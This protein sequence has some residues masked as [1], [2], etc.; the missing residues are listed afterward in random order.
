MS[1]VRLVG[2]DANGTFFDDTPQF[3]EA[4]NSIFD[5]FNKP[6]M[7][8]EEIREIFTQPWTKIY[9][10][11][12][13]T[14]AMASE[15]KLYELYNAAYQEQ[16]L[17]DLAPGIWSALQ[18]L[19][20]EQIP[21]WIISTQQNEITLPLLDRCLVL[22]PDSKILEGIPKRELMEWRSSFLLADVIGGVRDK[23]EAF[24]QLL[25]DFGA[26]PDEAVYVG[27]QD[28]DMTAAKK[29]GWKAVGYLGG[30]HSA[31]KLKVAG[32]DYLIRHYDEFLDLPIFN[33]K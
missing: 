9:R 3:F 25:V 2:F 23:T 22:N 32:A 15:A 14:E 7:S 17:P 18:S 20:T 28:S 4:L 11:A 19:R 24:K 10:D 33:K 5:H 12:G 6:R 8:I 21:A 1:G 31:E 13:I 16:P 26:D 30:V 29:V 27:D